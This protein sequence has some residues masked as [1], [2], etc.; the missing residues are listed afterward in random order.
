MAKQPSWCL[1]AA[2]WCLA[3]LPLVWSGQSLRAAQPG[4]DSPMP[5]AQQRKVAEDAGYK[6]AASPDAPKEGEAPPKFSADATK[7]G[8]AIFVRDYNLPIYPQGRVGQEELAAP[9]VI[10]AAWGETEPLSIGVHA[11]AG[12]SD[13]TVEVVASVGARGRSAP[14]VRVRYL[15]AAY[16]RTGGRRAKNA[17]LTRLRLRPVKPLP[18]AKGTSR[19][20]WIEATVPHRAKGEF[21]YKIVVRSKGR[22]ALARPLTVKVRPYALQEPS[23]FIGAF[24]STRIAPSVATFRE[25]KDH[26]VNGM[27]WFWSGLPWKFE[28]DGGKLKI[29]FSD[30]VTIIDRIAEAKLT[31]AVT[32]ALGN[33]RN[34]HYERD[35][36]SLYGRPLAEKTEVGGKTARVARLDDEVISKAYMEGVRQF[37]ELVKSK[38]KW[39]EVTLLHYDEPTERLM[40]EA[41]LRYKQIKKVAPKLRVYGVTMNRLRWAKMLA[42]ISDILVCNG[43]YARISALGEE[44][45]KA[46]WGYSSATASGGFGAGRFNMGLRL[47]RYKLGSHWFWCYDFFP[48]NPWN[49]FDA[50][51]GDADWVV[52]Y[53]GPAQGQHVPTLTW[54]GFREAYDDMRYAATLEKLLAGSKGAA[55]DRIAAEYKKFLAELPGRRGFRPEADGFYSTLPSYHKLTA[56]RAKLVGWIEQLRPAGG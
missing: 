34:G 44:T 37:N 22:P 20:F 2:G 28:I 6:I 27:L 56:L 50:S 1:L 13:L 26:G 19:Q 7:A 3:S 24:C 14:R 42:P 46:V 32:I 38:R 11:L 30:T 17:T 23:R 8:A 12:L 48:G 41:T 49:E 40:P 31:G 54:E 52:A 25:W 43:D 53:P 33:D 47:Y 29:D 5:L 4:K 16:I 35:L 15:E 9:A 51:P 45:G 36:C 21:G 10:A 18:L 39:P 55:R